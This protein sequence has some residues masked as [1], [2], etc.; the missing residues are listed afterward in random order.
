LMRWC[1]SQELCNGYASPRSE[2]GLGRVKTFARAAQVERF[3]SPTSNVRA[4]DVRRLGKPRPAEHDSPLY[5]PFRSFHTARDTFGRR[6]PTHGPALV[7]GLS[8]RKPTIFTLLG[9]SSRECLGTCCDAT[10]ARERRRR[11][12]NDG[13][14][15]VNGQAWAGAH[16]AA[17]NDGPQ[18][19]ARGTDRGSGACAHRVRNHCGETSGRRGPDRT[20]PGG[21]QYKKASSPSVED[22]PG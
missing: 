9:G 20:A 7:L 19:C 13:A 12:Y 16:G 2:S 8:H 4:R 1:T 5:T 21:A 18:W 14:R 10:I 6:H 11:V 22:A 15:V 17:K 3:P